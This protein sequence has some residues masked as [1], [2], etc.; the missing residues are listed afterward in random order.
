MYKAICV[1]HSRHSALREFGIPACL[2]FRARGSHSRHLALGIQYW[3][4]R[5]SGRSTRWVY[6]RSTGYAGARHSGPY[7]QKEK[8]AP[9]IYYVYLKA[10]RHGS[11]FYLQI[12]H[13]CLSFVCIHQ[14]APLLI[15]VRDI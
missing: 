1:R 2:A 10:L 4:V 7:L 8:E 12:H 14:M 6:R 3:S 13:A 11:Q 5:H 15:E 9:F